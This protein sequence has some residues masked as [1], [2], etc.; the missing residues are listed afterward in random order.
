MRWNSNVPG[1][2]RH[3]AIVHINRETRAEALR[4]YDI[5]EARTQYICKK[6]DRSPQFPGDFVT[7]T[8]FINFDVDTFAHGSGKFDTIKGDVASEHDFN[9][10]PDVLRRI[11]RIDQRPCYKRALQGFAW[12]HTDTS[13]AAFIFRHKIWESLRN[14]TL[15]L[16]HF[17]MFFFSDALSDE[18]KRGIWHDLSEREMDTFEIGVHV[19]SGDLGTHPFACLVKRNFELRT[20]WKTHPFARDFPITSEGPHTI[21]LSEP[22]AALLL[23]RAKKID[24]AKLKGLFDSYLVESSAFAFQ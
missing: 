9:F 3:P 23:A 12:I 1:Q 10:G 5:C 17:C 20:K 19:S 11:Q 6:V 8:Y 22:A 4:F 18:I 24:Q 2:A 7:N 13:R 14:V 15:F 16:D 21:L